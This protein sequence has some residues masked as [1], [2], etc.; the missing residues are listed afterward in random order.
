MSCFAKE[1]ILTQRSSFYM[2]PVSVLTLTKKST[3]M[4]SSS[5]LQPRVPI[6]YLGSWP[7][8][9]AP[10]PSAGLLSSFLV[11]HVLKEK[12]NSEDTLAAASFGLI[13][14]APQEC[15][16]ELNLSVKDAFGA[17]GGIVSGSDFS[18]TCGDLWIATHLGVFLRSA[19]VPSWKPPEFTQHKSAVRKCLWVWLFIIDFFKCS[20]LCGFSQ[21]L[22]SSVT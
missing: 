12:L 1:M 21:R 4:P 18:L 22:K 13:P 7:Y 11:P 8:G 20:L 9:P 15:A 2:F 3:E 10:A 16:W 6:S 5:C 19:L 14:W 17:P